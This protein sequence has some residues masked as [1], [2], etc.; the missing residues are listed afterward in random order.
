MLL[1]VNKVFEHDGR[2]YHLQ[3]EDMG[4]QAACFD[5]RVYDRGSVLWQKRVSYSD[6]IGRQ[7]PREE[8]EKELHSLMEKTVHTVQAAIAKGKLN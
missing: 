1:A 2:Q 8:Q 6:L 3:A 5:V 7:L 4:E